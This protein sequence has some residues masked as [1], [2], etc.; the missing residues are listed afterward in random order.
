[1][2]GRETENGDERQGVKSNRMT[3]WRKEREEM[4]QMTTL[5]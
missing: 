1:M 4:G 5:I 2:T 3:G